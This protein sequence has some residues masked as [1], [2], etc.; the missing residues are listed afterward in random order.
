MNTRIDPAESVHIYRDVW[1]SPTNPRPSPHQKEV[2]LEHGL[3]LSSMVIDAT[4]PFEWRDRFPPVAE[5]SAGLRQEITEKW[6][7]L[8]LGPQRPRI[9]A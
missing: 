3:T 5:M 8:I 7:D 1:I 2:P 6:G 9:L 4:R